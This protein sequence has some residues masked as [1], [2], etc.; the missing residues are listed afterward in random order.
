MFTKS[1]F[2]AFFFPPSPTLNCQMP[3]AIAV[4]RCG[5]LEEQIAFSDSMHLFEGRFNILVSQVFHTIRRDHCK[6]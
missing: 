6:E 1:S 3:V 5:Q 4:W 2:E